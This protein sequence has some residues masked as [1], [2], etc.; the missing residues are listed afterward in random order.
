MISYNKDEYVYILHKYKGRYNEGGD[1]MKFEDEEWI[2]G[3][4]GVEVNVKR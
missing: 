4:H 2:E 3:T 1:E